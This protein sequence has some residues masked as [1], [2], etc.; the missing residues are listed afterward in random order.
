MTTIP[1]VGFEYEGFEKLYLFGYLKYRV[2]VVFPSVA[3]VEDLAAFKLNL[4]KL[5][6][7][8]NSY[9]KVVEVC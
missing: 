3:E 5:D 2:V 1:L 6:Y 7:L 4:Y 8:Y 9:N